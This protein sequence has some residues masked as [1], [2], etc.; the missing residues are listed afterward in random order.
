MFE[1]QIEV[2]CCLCEGLGLNCLTRKVAQRA[3]EVIVVLRVYLVPYFCQQRS[4]VSDILQL[5]RVFNGDNCAQA[6]HWV[7]LVD[8]VNEIER[9]W[10][11]VL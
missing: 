4:A 3:L 6:A 1:Q 8:R 2:G 5:L 10:L 9:A 7:D 11:E